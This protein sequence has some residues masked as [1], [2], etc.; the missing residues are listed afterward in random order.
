MNFIKENIIVKIR[1]LFFRYGIKSVTMDDIAQELGISKKTLYQ[2]FATKTDVLN[3]VAE[4]NLAKDQKMVA[5][6]HL[7]ATDAIDE[8]FLLAHYLIEEIANIQSPTLL[9]DLQKYYPNN[10][11]EFEAVQNEQVYNHIK[12]NIERGIK[13]QLYR[14]NL[15][16]D[17][18]AKLYVSKCMC[19]IDEVNFPQKTY[20]KVTLFKD[21]F[22][23]HIRGI[24][25]PKGVK[26]LEK[27]LVSL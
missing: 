2:H 21:F 5:D 3:S 25:L 14:A 16:C 11:K 4:Y 19:V 20:D 1:N 9:Y 10:W 6:I 17:I 8:M 15:N 12:H 24:A 22:E 23:Y 18:I 26:L 13:E 7:K 27:R